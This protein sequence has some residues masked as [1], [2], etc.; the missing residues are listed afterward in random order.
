MNK[1]I[2]SVFSVLS[3]GALVAG[4]AEVR[5]S[6]FDAPWQEGRLSEAVPAGAAEVRVDLT[7]ADQEVLGFGCAMSELSWS[8]LSKLS[9]ADRKAVLDELFLPD[10]GNFTVIRTPIGSSDFA[11]QY[12]SY[13]DHPGDFG[14]EKFSVKRDEQYLIP[15]IREIQKR[16]PAD[17][18]RIWAS[19]WT[20]P[21]WMKVNGKYA[22][23][24][25]HAEYHDELR[26][27]GLDPDHPDGFY[28][29]NGLTQAD[30]M[31]EGEDGFKPEDRYLAAYAKYFRKYVDA[32]RSYGIPLWMV[33]PQ[34]E[35]NS[36]MV[37]SSCPW[38]TATLARF[39]GE[40]LGPALEG[41]GTEVFAGTIERPDMH[42]MSAVMAH[43]DAR[44]YVKGAGFQW[45]GKGSVAFAHRRY[46]KLFLVQT[47]QEC[48]AGLNNYEEARHCWELAKTYF[49]A[50]V[51]VYE[52]WNLALCDR[53]ISPWGWLQN[54][55]VT[56]DLKTGKAKLNAEYWG[57]KH[58]SHFVVR[59]SRRVET[60]G[61]D[62]ALAF[63]RPDG[64]VVA[65]VGNADAKP[66]AVVLRADGKTCALTLPPKSLATVVP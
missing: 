36:S 66:K 19:P 35:P 38:R 34:N 23:R 45:G 44:R 22:S 24:P 57:L 40:H 11:W 63:V 2:V 43:P 49:R 54:S 65:I 46:P 13:D 21:T 64:K 32:Y 26:A 58:L 16:V 61:Y 10:G 30:Y 9:E 59:G 3:V 37:Y 20:P 27:K 41:S 60:S 6:T 55:L 29:G 47:E 4:A 25:Y 7:K 48:G 33:M 53:Q 8:A 17:V 5:V 1:S 50:G 15:L 42:Y 14:M 52:Y 39:I 31:F 28:P 56:V 62:D 12:Y 51:S 18:L